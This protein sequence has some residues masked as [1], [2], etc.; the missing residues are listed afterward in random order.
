MI[1]ITF[2]NFAYIS[3]ILGTVLTGNKS[4][5]SCDL[6]NVGQGHHLQ[7]LLYLSFYTIDFYQTYRNNSTVASNINIISADLENV[8][9]DHYLQK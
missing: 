9:Q 5:S 8:G 6:E 3:A 2:Y 1:R 4:V 7:K